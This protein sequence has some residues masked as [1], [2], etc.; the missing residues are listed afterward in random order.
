MFFSLCYIR[1]ISNHYLTWASECLQVP[2]PRSSRNEQIQG[3]SREERREDRHRGFLRSSGSILKTV[4]IRYNFLCYP[5]CEKNQYGI[6][7][8]IACFTSAVIFF[9]LYLLG[10]IFISLVHSFFSSC[11]FFTCSLKRFQVLWHQRVPIKTR[12][13]CIKT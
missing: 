8:G 3:E 7:A 6:K 4:P 2:H 9:F 1:L 10:S 13:T 5:P 12:W 11:V